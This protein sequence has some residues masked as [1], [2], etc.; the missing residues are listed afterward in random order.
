MLKKY[1]YFIF[2]GQEGLGTGCT[3]DVEL[4]GDLV[5]TLFFNNMGVTPN[6]MLCL[7]QRL[8]VFYLA[9]IL[10]FKYFCTL[11]YNVNRWLALQ[12]VLT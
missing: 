9:I 1:L 8:G 2:G 5:L 11:F 12:E 6:M 4:L 10:V 3:G 7:V